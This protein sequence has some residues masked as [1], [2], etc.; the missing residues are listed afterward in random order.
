[1][2]DTVMAALFLCSNTVPAVSEMLCLVYKWFNFKYLVLI[3]F[4]NT[5]L[6]QFSSVCHQW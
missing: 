6:S 5:S 3:I 2:G 1:M 4:F